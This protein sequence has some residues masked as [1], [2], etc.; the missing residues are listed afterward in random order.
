MADPRN[1]ILSNCN[2]IEER[3]LPYGNSRLIHIL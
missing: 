3:E 2:E 1:E